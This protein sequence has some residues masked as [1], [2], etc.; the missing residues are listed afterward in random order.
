MKIYTFLD[1]D[2]NALETVKAE[3]HKEAVE[4]ANSWHNYGINSDTDYYSEDL[5]ND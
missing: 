3:D 5:D 4:N 1:E 2:G